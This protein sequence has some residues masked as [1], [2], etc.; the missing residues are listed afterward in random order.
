MKNTLGKVSDFI[1]RIIIIFT[2]LVALLFFAREYSTYAFTFGFLA[3]LFIISLATK[4]LVNIFIG[5]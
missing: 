3:I 5:E 1:V 2:T 4:G